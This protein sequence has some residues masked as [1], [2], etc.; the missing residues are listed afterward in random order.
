MSFMLLSVFLCHCKRIWLTTCAAKT[1][2]NAFKT[3]LRTLCWSTGFLSFYCVLKAD[4]CPIVKEHVLFGWLRATDFL[5]N[6]TEKFDHKQ[7]LLST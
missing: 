3:D 2:R 7:F 5:T 6:T 1:F 4:G